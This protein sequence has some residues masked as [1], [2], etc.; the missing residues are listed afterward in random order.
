MTSQFKYVQNS[1]VCSISAANLP[2]DS[3]SK[4]C[5][6]FIVN[7]LFYFFFLACGFLTGNSR[8][9]MLLERLIP[10]FY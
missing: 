9:T 2:S 1:R 8:Y 5:S 10:Y 3:V 7:L 6:I 4:F